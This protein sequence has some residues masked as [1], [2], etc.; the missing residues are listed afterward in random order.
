M[1][2]EFRAAALALL[3]PCDV[4]AEPELLGWFAERLHGMNI[5]DSDHSSW[6]RLE[7]ES[8]RATGRPSADL[9]V[10]V[11][12]ALFDTNRKP[13][14][15]TFAQIGEQA[16]PLAEQRR[17]A[18]ARL[19]ERYFDLHARLQELALTFDEA[20][21]LLSYSGVI[22]SSA[23]E[24]LMS[25]SEISRTLG[26]RDSR[27]ALNWYP[28]HAITRA[29][30]CAATFG[31]AEVKAS[32]RTTVEAEPALLADL[33][34]E[35]ATEYV[36]SIG[37]NLG[38]K[39]DLA[40]PLRALVIGDRHDPYLLILH[41]QLS[42]L[43][44]CDHAVTFAYEFAPR[45]QAAAWLINQYQQAGLEVAANP[46]LN[47]AKALL[48]FSRAWAWGRDDH[49]AQA[50]ALVTV[51]EEVETLGT[52][53]KAELS[54]YIR[55]LLRRIARISEETNGGEFPNKLP[56]ISDTRLAQLL[57]DLATS[58]TATTGILE[59][60]LADAATSA[61][62]EG[63]AVRGRGDSVFAASTSRRKLGDIEFT[64][65][66]TGRVQVVGYEAHGGRVT[67]SYVDGHIASFGNILL[68]RR[69]ELEAVA[70]PSGW[71]LTSIFVSHSSD[72]GLP[73]KVTL[74]VG[75]EE[76]ELTLQYES[77]DK[78]ASELAANEQGG[79]LVDAY[80]INPLNRLQVPASVRQKVL[81]LLS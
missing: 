72:P 53:P 60:R 13:S 49:R 78:L 7:L 31:L 68:G 51:L 30:G 1:N 76:V 35:E 79:A 2:H 12:E 61:R 20:R 8:W 32:Y 19:S 46:Y 39:L 81:S 22:I 47:N 74:P 37:L 55:A 44:V 6:L 80:F 73:D 48:S 15:F 71:K 41:F 5:D 14:S 40:G 45:G 56:Q 24:Q 65:F 10:L 70:P 54:R 67:R 25:A 4:R 9:R 77:F 34:I 27:L 50:H 42:I 59:Q 52:L 18:C 17:S 26:A 16:G 29:C 57:R 21:L 23:L 64:L 43:D 75:D 63:W 28:V 38:C 11:R 66:E 3:I 33:S 62:H 36:G 69:I 58:N